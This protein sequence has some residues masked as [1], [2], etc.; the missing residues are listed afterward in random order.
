VILG[1][2]KRFKGIGY[3]C[4]IDVLGFSNDILKNWKDPTLNP[5]G[6]ILTIKRDMPGFPEIAEDDEHESHRIYLCRVNTISDSVTICFGYTDKIIIGDLVL[7]LEAILGNISFVWSKFIHNGYTVRGAID[8][9]DIYWDESELI[10]PAFIN[11]YRLES[12]AAR[13]SRVIVSS[14]LN[15]VFKDL[16]STHRGSLTDHLMQGFRKDVDGYTIVNPRI[17]YRSDSERNSL[18][19][20]LKKMR[21]AVPNEILKEKYNPLINMLSEVEK[22]ELKD[23]DDGTF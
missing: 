5:L 20:S 6:K 3:V 10:G 2:S 1:N 17:L 14:N 7:G 9:G 15:K 22:S 8:F 13:V 11:A 23:K 21:D 19:D 16:L 18:I 4:F 12:E